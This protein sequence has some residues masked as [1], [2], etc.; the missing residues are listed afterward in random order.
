MFGRTK[1]PCLFTPFIIVQ[2]QGFH[3]P[4]EIVIL[5]EFL[6]FQS[7]YKSI[8]EQLILW[9]FLYGDVFAL[10]KDSSYFCRVGSEWLLTEHIESV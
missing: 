10:I 6:V 7:Y 3:K 4:V 5:D 1:M 2:I 8:G 9:L